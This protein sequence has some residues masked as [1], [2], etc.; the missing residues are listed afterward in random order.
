MTG[1]RRS[2]WSLALLGVAGFLLAGGALS[3]LPG[4]RGIGLD[5]AERATAQALFVPKKP[6]S[7][8]LFRSPSLNTFRTPKSGR[9]RRW[10]WP[11]S[12]HRP[13]GA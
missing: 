8:R 11:H 10:S 5:I 7:P 12:F 1:L 2:P 6:S 3:V 13:P 4:L 9:G